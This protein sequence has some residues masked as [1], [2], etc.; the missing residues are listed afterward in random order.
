V[1]PFTG[2]YC[3]WIND[4]PA[5]LSISESGAVSGVWESGHREPYDLNSLSGTVADDGSLDVT[6]TI[7]TVKIIPGGT[8]TGFPKTK[9]Q[10]TRIPATGFVELDSEGNLSGW[11]TFETANGEAV[12]FLDLIRC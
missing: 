3:G 2:D 5:L 7:V 1:S 6:L 10:W 8:K 4:R 11:I 12:L 9:R